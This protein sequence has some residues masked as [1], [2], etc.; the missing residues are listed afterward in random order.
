MS[1][2]EQYDDAMFEFSTGNFPAAIA[3]LREIL[4]TDARHF[5]AQLAL[6]MAYCRLGDFASAIEEGL[7]AEQLKPEEQLVHTNLS[8]FYL[9]SGDKQKAEQHGLKARIS[10]WK[11]P[12]SGATANPPETELAQAKPPPPPPGKFANQPW[13]KKP[14]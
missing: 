8:L 7:K 1:L 4:A 2:E 9:K 13:K 6:G 10:S 14:E 3:K 11:T 12:P 5:D